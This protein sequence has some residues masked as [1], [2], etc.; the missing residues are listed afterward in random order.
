MDGSLIVKIAVILAFGLIGLGVLSM[1]V[2]AVKSL[3]QG[4]QDFKRIAL[5]AVPFIV[6]GISY[7]VMTSAE[8]PLVNAGVMTTM[9]MMG[10]M[11]VSTV[12][13]GLRSTF[14]F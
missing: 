13:T 4:K 7:G 14:K 3:M 2:S 6:F 9:V 12:I 5:M 11:V 8:Q 1:I 10:I